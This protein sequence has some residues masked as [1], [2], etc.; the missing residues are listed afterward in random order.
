MNQRNPYT[1]IQTATGKQFW[2]LEA[3][4][5]E[6]SIHDIAHALSNLCRF[7]GHT[8]EFYSVAQHSVLV[9]QAVPAEDALWGLLHD[10]TEA[11]INDLNRPVKYSAGLETY[12]AIEHNLMRVIAQRFGLDPEMPRS[13]A[14]ADDRMLL[15][16]RRDLLP[17]SDAAGWQVSDECVP[18]PAKII[19]WTPRMAK[20][21]FIA[22]YVELMT[23]VTP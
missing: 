23:G 10:A 6:V 19:P 20:T 16:E 11:Y 22:R 17:F 5:N 18:Y 9:S 2:P 13:V 1:W 12:R 4:P 15:T 8:A 14:E 3:R 21:A 7:T